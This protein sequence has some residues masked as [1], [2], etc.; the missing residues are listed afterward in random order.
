M[1]IYFILHVWTAFVKVNFIEHMLTG[2]VSCT[3]Y[4]LSCAVNTSR[5]VLHDGTAMCLCDAGFSGDAC[6]VNIDDCRDV[7]CQN[8]GTCVD[9]TLAYHC[10]CAP[11]YTGT[12][13]G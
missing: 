12:S 7:T 9:A 3:K 6:D 13:Y 8:G 5:C 11:G 4:S 1:F 10:A 2:V